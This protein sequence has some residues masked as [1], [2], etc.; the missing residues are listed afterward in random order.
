MTTAV[1]P[2][3]T[4]VVKVVYLE[5]PPDAEQDT[6]RRRGVIEIDGVEYNF[7]AG[8]AS[9]QPVPD[10]SRLRANDVYAPRRVQALYDAYIPTTDEEDRKKH[11]AARLILDP[12][13]KSRSII[14]GQIW[15]L[16]VHLEKLTD[17]VTDTR[18]RAWRIAFWDAWRELE[19]ELRRAAGV[20]SPGTLR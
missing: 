20:T 9:V 12:Y 2:P 7:E 17:E 15:E 1:A 8:Q 18:T 6:L 19:I 4:P 14:A 10:D 5:P 3:T 11:R 13:F 16:L